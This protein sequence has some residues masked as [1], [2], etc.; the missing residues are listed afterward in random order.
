[1]KRGGRWRFNDCFLFANHMCRCLRQGGVTMVTPKRDFSYKQLY[2]LF[3]TELTH[4]PI[5]TLFGGSRFSFCYLNTQFYCRSHGYQDASFLRMNRDEAARI[6]RK[7]KK[8]VIFNQNNNQFIKR[9]WQ[10]KGDQIDTIKRNEK[11]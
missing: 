4:S 2:Y 10:K 3:I 7:G 1:M 8:L 6:M 5:D 9:Y 11:W